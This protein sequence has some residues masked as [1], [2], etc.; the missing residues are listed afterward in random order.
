MTGIDLRNAESMIHVTLTTTTKKMA[1]PGYPMRAIN[2][3]AIIEDWGAHTTFSPYDENEH[4]LVATSPLSTIIILIGKHIII[5]I[6]IKQLL[7]KY[8]NF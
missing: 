3:N 7:F 1:K 4:A 8:F 2:T 5:I 6:I